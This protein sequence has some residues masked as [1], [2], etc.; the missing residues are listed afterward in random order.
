MSGSESADAPETAHRASFENAAAEVVSQV[1][2]TWSTMMGLRCL[3]LNGTF[4]AAQ[5]RRTGDLLVKLDRGEVERMI[6]AG[7]GHP[8]APAGRRFRERVAVPAAVAT[9]GIPAGSWVRVRRSSP[10]PGLTYA[11]SATETSIP[12]VVPPEAIRQ[13]S[14]WRRGSRPGL[15]GRSGD[16][17]SPARPSDP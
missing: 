13:E 11:S 9:H 16:R 1:G 3:R 8:F 10:R 12:S 5:D 7:H 4:F 6:E 17:S 2:V 15:C 14:V